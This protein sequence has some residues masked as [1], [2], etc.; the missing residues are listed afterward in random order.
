MKNPETQK[1]QIRFYTE[2]QTEYIKTNWHIL[3]RFA[4]EQY[5][6][7][8]NRTVKQIDVKASYEK[9]QE[10]I[11]NG[12]KETPKRIWGYT[13]EQDAEILRDFKSA[14]PNGKREMA[15]RMGKADVSR[16]KKRYQLLLKR[17]A[18]K[19][20]VEQK[21]KPADIIITHIE[22]AKKAKKRKKVKNSTIFIGKD[23]RVKVPTR[24]F[25]VSGV[26]IKW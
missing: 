22:K 25:R 1:K 18:K 26:K 5:A 17:E 16:I 7:A 15:K 9:K 24:T 23:V 4:K 2:E 6:K 3:G 14:G 8:I 13:P 11:K 10:R 21:Q 20:T 19:E 12:E